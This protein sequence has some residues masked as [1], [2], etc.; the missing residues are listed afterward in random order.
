MYSG[1]SNNIVA[2]CTYTVLVQLPRKLFIIEG[3]TVINGF[4]FVRVRSCDLYNQDN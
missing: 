1:F 4:F 2:K 3:P